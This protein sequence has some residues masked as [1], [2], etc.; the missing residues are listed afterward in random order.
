MRHGSGGRRG[1][2]G[3]SRHGGRRG[4]GSS[5]GAVSHI[6]N[7]FTVLGPQLKCPFLSSPRLTCTAGQGRN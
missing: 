5:G 3:I 1:I 2:G 6:P 7:M 4:S